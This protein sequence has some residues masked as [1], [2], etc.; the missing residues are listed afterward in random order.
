MLFPISL[1]FAVVVVL[2]VRLWQIQRQQAEAQRSVR[3]SLEKGVELTPEL[4]HAMGVRPPATDLRRGVVLICIAAAC[5]LFG[6]VDAIEDGD[7]GSLWTFLAIAAGP[8]LI[9]VALI[10]FHFTDR[11]GR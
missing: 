5:A 6:V 8:A 2:C 10:V 4:L 11:P 3:A 9:G 7:G 1:L